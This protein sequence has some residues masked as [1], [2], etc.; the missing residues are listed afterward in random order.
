MPPLKVWLW[1]A[2]KIIIAVELVYVVLLNAALQLPLTQTLVNKIKPDKFHVSWENAWTW[3]PFRVHAR[4]VFVNGQSRSQQWQFETPSV[5]GSISILPLIIKKV[6]VDDVT[7]T[8][9]DYRQRPRL[10]ADKD[11]TNIMEYFPD[12]EG[13]EMTPAVT[14]PRKKKS[15]QID[16]ENIS[17]SGDHSYWI[18][19]LKGGAA[20]KVSADL[21]YDTAQRVFS[22]DARDVDLDLDT[23]YVNENHEIFRQGRVAGTLGFEPFAPSEHKDFSMLGFVLADLVMDLDV[24]SLAFIDLFTLDELKVDGRGHV[25]GRLHFEKGH[26]LEGT[27]LSIEADDLLVKVPGHSM[28]GEGTISM[29]TG[30]ETSDSMALDIVYRNLEVFQ[31]HERRALLTG[32]HLALLIGGDGK[33]LPDPDQLNESRTI[34]LEIEDLVIPDLSSFQHYVPEKWPFQLHA[35]EGSLRG[36]AS[37]SPKAL[38]L[39]LRIASESA[40]LGF[41][42]YRFDTN[43]DAAIKL[44]NPSIMSEDTQIGGTY[45]K[46]SDALLQSADQS[47]K[48]PWHASLNIDDGKF[49]IFRDRQKHETD[50][51]VDLFQVLGNTE[52]RQLLGNSRGVMGFNATVSSLAWIGVLL[53][54]DHQTGFEGSSTVQGDFLLEAGLPAVGTD[55]VI[56]SDAL[57]VNIMDYISS[58]DGQIR[59]RV[60]EGGEKPDWLLD[61]ELEDADLKRQNE[62][63]AVIQNVNLNLNALVEDMTFEE[64]KKEFSL[65]FKIQ[66]AEVTEMSTFNDFFPPDSPVLL[67]SGTAD[68][69]ADIVLQHDDADGWLSLDSRGLVAQADAQTIKADLAADILLVGGVPA[70]MAFD[71]SGSVLRLNNVQVIGESEEFNQDYW[72]AVVKLVRGETTWTRP[73]RLTTEAEI[74]ISDSRPI[75]A[76]FQNQDGWR[77]EFLANMLTVEDITGTVNMNVANEIISI[78]HAHVISDNI[79]AGAKATISGKENDG[80]VYVRYKKASAIVKISD[81]KKNLD[82]IQPL[83]KYEEYRVE[84]L[85]E[86]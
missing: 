68:L 61:V 24:N 55:V 2:A 18:F 65:A 77:P 85:P 37:L 42:H 6:W 8:N 36:S 31:D 67:S 48:T 14:T 41:Q 46:L 70:D 11:Y 52:T 57:A 25:G 39:D 23:L 79:E 12:I 19:N 69:T 74:Q 7:A 43:L 1:K 51:V 34:G 59:F 32:Q 16:I 82:I 3:Y 10:K 28:E 20:G 47:E 71:I 63:V 26:V 60:K 4:G 56:T 76:M 78:P 64:G 38:E 58:G 62:A 5:S 9:V 45:I 53:G 49:S 83:K 27:D 50:H 35:G 86:P 72:S 21:S 80:V 22:L 15:W 84:P 73:P 17:I 66:S 44:V 81:G 54:K 75:V 29:K 33:V 30:P 40:D 13:W